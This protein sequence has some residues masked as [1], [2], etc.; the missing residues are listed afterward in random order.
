MDEYEDFVTMLQCLNSASK[1]QLSK[2]QID[3]LLTK[4]IRAEYF[5]EAMKWLN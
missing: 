1:R 4:R 5:E 2:A 3:W